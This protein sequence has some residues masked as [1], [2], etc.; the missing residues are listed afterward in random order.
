[1]NLKVKFALLFSLL[2]SIILISSVLVIYFLYSDTRRED[3]NKRLWAEAL[4]NYRVFFHVDTLD[5][6]LLREIDRN[7]PA[8][9]VELQ[10]VILDV[11]YKQVYVYPDTLQFK[12][13]KNLLDKIRWNKDGYFYSKG[14]REFIGMYVEEHGHDS[15][16]IT[17]AVDR[18]GL[19]K[20]DRL[21]LIIG[22]VIFGGI[23][24][25]A[26][27][28]FIF[29][30]QVIKP[31]DKMKAQMHRITAN[32]LRE[33][34]QVG[35]GYD[36]LAQI[37]ESFNAM[38]ERLEKGFE[39][40][41]SFVHHASHELRTPLANMLAQT[42]AALNRELN[43]A[44]AKEV[45]MSLKEDQHALIELA[46]SLLLLS[47]YERINYSASWQ[48][49][50]LDEILYDTISMA[51]QVFPDINVTV[52]FAT[53]PENEDDLAVKCNEALLR[54]AV[55]NL[56]KNAYLYSTNKSMD[57]LI[58]VK[59]QEVCLHVDNDGEVLTLSEQERLFIPF[60]RGGNAIRAKGFGLGLLI[61]R[62]IVNLHRGAIIYSIHEGRNRFT[63]SFPKEVPVEEEVL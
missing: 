46:N 17:S 25:T 9:L 5:K 24:L 42:E 16:I 40:Q 12:A 41:K 8:N 27:C 7:S 48:A 21:R 45:L 57:V 63:L 10:T 44:Q 20:M 50:R 53:I 11:S 61:V 32:N 13:D 59:E 3:F 62:R 39:L 28:A 30:K 15:Y 60:F 22:F 55:R 31:L 4:Q 6:Q 56:I 2:V 14:K 26:L 38:L 51:H 36:E 35:K 37:A 49:V 1:M 52:N 33:R 19:R 29:V 18:Y 54:S 47:Q 34:V 43:A 23:L 58:E